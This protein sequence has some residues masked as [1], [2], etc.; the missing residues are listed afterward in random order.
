MV[1]RPF[2]LEEF[3]VVLEFSS[4]LESPREDKKLMPAPPAR[5]ANVLVTL[6][7]LGG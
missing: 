3:A 7:Q 1:L 6:E 5:D 4:A 2:Q